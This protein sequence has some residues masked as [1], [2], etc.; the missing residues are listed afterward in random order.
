MGFYVRPQSLRINSKPLEPDDD[1]RTSICC[2]CN[3]GCGLKVSLDKEGKVQAVFGDLD[4]PYNKGKICAKPMEITQTLYGPY[5]V[6]Y[7]MK[8]V[9]GKFERITWDEALE[10]IAQKYNHYV[11]ESGTGSI[12]GITSKI[13]GSYS[14]LA[15]SIFSKL[16][17][18]VNY[19]TGPICMESELNVRREIFGNGSAS[20][21]LSDVVRSK[22]LLIVGNNC[23]QTKAGQF[24]WILKA[25]QQGTKIVVVDTRFTETAQVADRFIQIKPGTDAALGMALL[26]FI[27]KI[28][29]MINPLSLI[30]LMDFNNCPRQ[31]N[32]LPW[33]E[34]RT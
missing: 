16:T 30:I 27:I 8:K 33:S 28:I 18:M 10:L 7:P 19:G 17:G 12:V 24:H 26:E 32:P 11:Q 15:H 6:G 23:A 9:D 13:G 20:G 29:S 21:A 4:N 31:W 34:H 3:G 5:R 22:I 1:L 14:K 25:K 2:L